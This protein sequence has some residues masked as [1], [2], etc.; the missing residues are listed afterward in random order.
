MEKIMEIT[1]VLCQMLQRK[2]LDSLNALDCVWNTTLLLG[3]LLLEKIESFFLKYD[4]DIS[5]FNSEYVSFSYIQIGMLIITSI[6]LHAIS[7]YV[8]MTKC[9]NKHDNNTNTAPL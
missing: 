1:D 8:D 6:L 3:E 4:I 2:S 5:N 7:W 9:R